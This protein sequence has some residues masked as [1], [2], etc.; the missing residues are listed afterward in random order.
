M[1]KG[2]VHDK[3]RLKL[4]PQHSHPPQLYGL[5]KVHKEGIPLRPI[6][7]SIGSATYP[8]L[9]QV[10]APL[11]GKSTSCIKNSGDFVAKIQSLSLSETGILVSFDVKS[12]FTKVPIP[13]ALEVIQRRLEHDHT[14]DE[15]TLMSP[16]TVCHLIKL[17]MTST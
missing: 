1:E 16:G 7:S 12:L 10:L 15:S 3:Q 6:V 8:D 13:E 11:Q 17:C 4:T 2:E 5:S 14:L 9:A